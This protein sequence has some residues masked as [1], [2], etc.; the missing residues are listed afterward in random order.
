MPIRNGSETDI[1]SLIPLLQAFFPTH[2]KLHNEN[3]K[4]YLK[5]QLKNPLLI[6]D[7]NGIKGALFLVKLD[8]N[9]S[10]TRWRLR[11]FAYENEAAATQLLKAAEEYI[12][13]QSTTA[14]IEVN[15]AQ[16]EKGI[17]FYKANGFEVEGQLKN[18]Y[19]WNETTTIVGKS[20]S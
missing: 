18:H 17:Q 9:S 3:V 16:S 20:L 5:E 11:H 1:E 14:K 19:R 13:E 4:E 8:D 7:D 6:Y 15:I 2:N 12:K 10:H